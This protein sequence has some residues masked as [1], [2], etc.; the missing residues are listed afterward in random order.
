M[1][2]FSQIYSVSVNTPRSDRINVRYGVNAK[3]LLTGIFV[4]SIGILYYCYFRSAEYTY[5]KN[6]LGSYP[7]PKSILPPFILTIG[8]SLPAFIHVFAF[9]L[10]TASLLASQKRGYVIICF[11]WFF[12]EVLFELGQRFGNLI[13][14]VIPDWFSDFLFLENTQDYFLYGHFDYFDL[15]SIAIGSASA[16]LFLMKS[17]GGRERTI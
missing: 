4:L 11:A 9:T 5:F 6:F 14:P 3:Q 1:E 8:N 12:M 10:I 2:E 7:H 17:K 13:I 15:L 16:Y